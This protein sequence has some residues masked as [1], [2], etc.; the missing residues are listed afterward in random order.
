MDKKNL[1]KELIEK[2]KKEGLKAT[3]LVK[4]GDLN[5]KKIGIEK[6]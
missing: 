3:G 5:M 1:K 2:S 4:Q 6:L